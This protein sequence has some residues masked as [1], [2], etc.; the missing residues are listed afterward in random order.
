MFERRGTYC[1]LSAREKEVVALLFF[2]SHFLFFVLL[3]LF[4]VLLG[5][6]EV[7]CLKESNVKY[8]FAFCLRRSVAPK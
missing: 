5:E 3:V 6:H 2:M 4:L 7:K 8:C 1:Y